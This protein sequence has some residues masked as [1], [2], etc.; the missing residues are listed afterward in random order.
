MRQEALPLAYRRTAFSVDDM[1]DLI[2]LLLAIG[3]LGR[4]NIE[5]LD[6]AWQSRADCDRRWDMLPDSEEMVTALPTLHAARCT[7]LLKQCKRLKFLKLC[8][9]SDLITNISLD[10]FQADPGIRELCSVRGI[11]RVEICDLALK[12]LGQDGPAKWLKEQM[13]SPEDSET[14][15]QAS[16]EQGYDQA[17]T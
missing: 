9:D 11:R 4:D 10:I 14:R 12:P 17:L 15:T 7:Q 5:S 16:G 6:L 13:E 2:R 8:F 3:K 1:D